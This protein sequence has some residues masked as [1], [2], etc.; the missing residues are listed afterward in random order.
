MSAVLKP[1]EIQFRPMRIDDLPRIMYIEERAYKHPWTIGIFRSCL[2]V[3]YPCW[4][5]EQDHR[6]LGY[7]AI[8]V[9]V[10]ECHILNL[11]VDPEF[12]GQGLGRRLLKHLMD[13]GIKHGA[14]TA[15]LEV[16]VSNEAAIH[17]YESEGFHRIG[18]RKDYYPDDAGRED[19]HVFARELVVRDELA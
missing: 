13:I 14:E 18:E 15:F 9:Q 10:G 17:L 11:T 19:A 4:L 7:G 5:I 8:M 16:R 3:N 1:G 2:K 12:Q 6:I